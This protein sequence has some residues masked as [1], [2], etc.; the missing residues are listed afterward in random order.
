MQWDS[1]NAEALMAM[2]ALYQSHLWDAWWV[3]K[4]RH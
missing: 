3:R 4:H 2:Q 1:D